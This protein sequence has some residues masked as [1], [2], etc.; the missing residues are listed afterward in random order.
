MKVSNIQNA[1]L[2]KLASDWFQRSGWSLTPSSDVHADLHGGNVAY[3]CD[4][5]KNRM[6]VK[7]VEKNIF[8][9]LGDDTTLRELK[10]DD[11]CNA[12]TSLIVDIRNK[13]A[14]D[15]IDLQRAFTA[16]IFLYISK[17]QCYAAVKQNQ[18]SNAQYVVILHRDW[19]TKDWLLRPCAISGI[20][21]KNPSEIEII[22]KKVISIDMMNHPKRFKSAKI[23]EFTL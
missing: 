12:L 16:L 4:I 19:E 17:T 3:L 20:N 10:L 8:E 18:I 23:L 15:D 21:V 6:V 7:V 1:K 14:F 13:Q 2:K 11:I 22:C 5:E 9:M